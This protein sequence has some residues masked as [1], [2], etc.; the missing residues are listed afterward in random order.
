VEGLNRLREA[1]SQWSEE[2]KCCNFWNG[3]SGNNGYDYVFHLTCVM[4]I[5]VKT[6]HTSYVLAKPK[7]QT[8]KTPNK[9]ISSAIT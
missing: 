4:P 1:N 9:E 7:S 2:G 5:P 3:S 8:V 6:L